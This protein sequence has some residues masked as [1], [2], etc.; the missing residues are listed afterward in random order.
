MVKLRADSQ[1]LDDALS[2]IV[3]LYH[4][5]DKS[6]M[7]QQH[8]IMKA[9]DELIGEQTRNFGLMYGISKLREL[10]LTTRIAARNMR[11]L[12]PPQHAGMPSISHT[13]FEQDRTR[14]AW[15]KEQIEMELGY[16]S[17]LRERAREGHRVATLM[18]GRETQKTSL[19]L[20]NLV[21]LQGTLIGSI[22]I[23]LLMLPAFDAFKEE[24]ARLVVWA[25]LFLL[26]ALVLALP[27]LFE[28]WHER[29]T[30]VDRIAGGL[31]GAAAFFF[32]V[33]LWEYI[34]LPVTHVSVFLYVGF[35]VV[36]CIPG[37]VCGYFAVDRL[38]K[39]KHTSEPRVSLK[40]DFNSH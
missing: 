38:E 10:G 4:Q 2:G 40:A 27:T 37:F 6:A 28:R 23:G 14:A 25:L 1:P 16:L 5:A 29:Y 34:G 22:T 17:A 15:L 39:H 31:L 24:K 20:K 30:S 13:L 11:N 36:V 26:M 35:Q 19:R 8:E 9:H 3:S 32:A 12:V 7:L 33:T 21:L 18:L